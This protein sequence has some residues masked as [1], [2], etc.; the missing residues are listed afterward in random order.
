M[1]TMI[2]R[3]KDLEA[4]IYSADTHEA[5]KHHAQFQD[6]LTEAWPELL[7]HLERLETE[8]ALYKGVVGELHEERVRNGK[9][10]AVVAAAKVMRHDGWSRWE[11]TAWAFEHKTV[12]A[13]DDALAALNGDV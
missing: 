9:L 13:L 1:K 10:L 5:A 4:R 8:N 6:A 7:S 2:E 12:E 11:K 3:L